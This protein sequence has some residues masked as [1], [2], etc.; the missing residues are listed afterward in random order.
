MSPG[1]LF[2][3][4]LL[5]TARQTRHYLLRAGAV[6]MAFAVLYTAGQV[7][8]GFQQVRTTGDTARFGHFV[9]N[10]LAILQLTVVMAVA[11]MQSASTV[12]TEKDRRTLVILLMTDLSGFELVVGK[13]LAAL[14]NVVTVVLV[15]TGALMI[16]RML[17]GVTIG[18]IVAL[19]LLCLSAGLMAAAWA[20]LVAYWRE[21]TFQTLA[22]SALGLMGLLGVTALVAAF[23]PGVGDAFAGLNPYLTLRRIVTPLAYGDGLSIASLAAGLIGPAVLGVLLL[24]VAVAKVRVWNPPRVVHQQAEEGEAARVRPPRSVWK[25]PVLWREIRTLAYGRKT[26]VIKGVFL[27]IA[28]ALFYTGLTSEA[29]PLFGKLP[30]VGVS[31]VVLSLLGLL[32]LNAQAVTSLTTERDG[33]TLEL[34][35]VTEVPASEFVHGKFLGALWN[36]KEMI[37]APLILIWVGYARAL[38]G[39]ENSVFVTIGFLTLVA[40]AAMLGLHFGLNYGSSRKAIGGS[41]GT[42]AF[43]FLGI[44]ICMLLIVEGQSNFAFQF[45]PFLVFI[46]GGAIALWSALTARTPSPALTFGALIL[47]FLTFYALASFLLGNTLGVMLAVVVAYGFTAFAMYV[48]SVSEYVVAVGRGRGD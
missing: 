1:P 29:A 5:T 24:A 33:Q 21:K 42:M 48:P 7:V 10:V 27:L 31:L 6:L 32:L 38:I 9:F 15:S 30:P 20:T 26:V 4:D 39:L 45:T 46:L 43:L 18:Q 28:A 14:I 13:M 17:G 16:V 41:L 11:L 8:F 35:L 40:F 44:F 47:P 12:S 25:T 23:A 36:S 2:S 3:R 19:E 37:L 22:I 34:L